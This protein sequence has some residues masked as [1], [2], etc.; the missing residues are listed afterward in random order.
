MNATEI[1]HR[2]NKQDTFLVKALNSVSFINDSSTF[3]SKGRLQRL[4]TLTEAQSSMK[5]EDVYVV[6]VPNKSAN[7]ILK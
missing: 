6:R 5:F 3:P 7:Q 1:L 4:R 2:D